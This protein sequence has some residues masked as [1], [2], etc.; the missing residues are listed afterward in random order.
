MYNVSDC[1][2][3]NYKQEAIKAGY[4]IIKRNIQTVVDNKG[5]KIGKETFRCI[6]K[7]NKGVA[8]QLRLGKKYIK[9]VKSDLI[10]SS[11]QIKR[12]GS[13]YRKKN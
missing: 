9:V 12:K 4:L 6:A 1:T 7:T 3:N 13:K 5:N 2:A 11:I 8:G 10:Y